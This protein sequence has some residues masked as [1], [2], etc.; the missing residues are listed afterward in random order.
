[1]QEQFRPQARVDRH[2]ILHA[3][4]TRTGQ[5]D[6]RDPKRPDGD[7]GSNRVVCRQC[8]RE[9]PTLRL[10]RHEDGCRAAEPAAPIE[11]MNQTF[12][13]GTASAGPH[14]SEAPM[15]AVVGRPCAAVDAPMQ[16][17]AQRVLTTT[18]THWNVRMKT[19]N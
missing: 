5:A 2:G 15:G 11:P 14:A 19:R 12:S 4:L 16:L 8:W 18:R 10:L 17:N 3:A 9:S 6:P 13:Q 7:A 1:M